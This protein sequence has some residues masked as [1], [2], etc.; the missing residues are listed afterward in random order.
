MTR[1]SLDGRRIDTFES[2][3]KLLAEE[4]ARV[5]DAK[6][7]YFRNSEEPY[8]GRNFDS[9]HDCLHGGLL[10]K[11]PYE[12]VVTNASAFSSTWDRKM[13][14]AYYRQQYDRID[15]KNYWNDPFYN[16]QCEWLSDAGERAENGEGPTFLEELVDLFEHAGSQLILR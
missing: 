8:F 5:C 13:L 14:S 1:V 3:L 6:P 11:A 2:F 9:L 16:D 12:V 10:G 7:P 15:S 4:L